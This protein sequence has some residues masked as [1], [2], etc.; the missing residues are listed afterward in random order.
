M[1]I[2]NVNHNT[3]NEYDLYLLVYNDDLDIITAKFDNDF[4]ASL[5]LQLIS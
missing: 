2:K 4:D 1:H 3:L 5:N